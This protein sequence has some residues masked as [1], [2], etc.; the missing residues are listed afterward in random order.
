M[1][2]YESTFRTLEGVGGGD[3]FVLT[4]EAER[5]SVDHFAYLKPSDGGSAATQSES[6]LLG[7]KI[8]TETSLVQT[9]QASD[10]IAD[11]DVCRNLTLPIYVILPRLLTCPIT[12][13]GITKSIGFR[14]SVVQALM[15]S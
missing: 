6:I 15:H 11:G 2:S 4:I 12:L 7:E 1:D 5:I 8:V 9:T 14:I 3:I 13:A 10:A